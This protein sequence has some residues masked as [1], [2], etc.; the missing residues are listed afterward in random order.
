MVR[1]NT[2]VTIIACGIFKDELQAVL[3]KQQMDANIRWI[4]AALHTDLPQLEAKINSSLAEV[5]GSTT[6]PCVL[7]GSGCLPE[8]CDVVQRH[9]AHIFS[10]GNCIDA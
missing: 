4:D 3:D 2:A 5:N 8:I 6:D 7:F 10:A 9:G 1:D